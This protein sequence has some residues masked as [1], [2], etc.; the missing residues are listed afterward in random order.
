MSLNLTDEEASDILSTALEG[1][2]TYWLNEEYA[3]D[4]FSVITVKDKSML[5][6][7]YAGL[8][9]KQ[10]KKDKLTKRFV[11]GLGDIK[12][13]ADAIVTYSVKVHKSIIADI[14]TE[15]GACDAESADAVLQVAMLGELVFG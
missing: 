9:V 8:I 13:A 10:K 14:V 1:G 7:S 5:G 15:R 4:A 2:S 11:I 12:L 6:W 3:D